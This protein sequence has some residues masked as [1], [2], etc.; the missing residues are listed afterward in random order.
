MTEPL[1]LFRPVAERYPILQR[2]GEN[3]HR[4]PR[5]KGHTGLDFDTPLRT[6]VFAAMAG[7]VIIIGKDDSYGNYLMIAQGDLLQVYAHLWR[8]PFAIVRLNE[9]VNQGQLI[10]LSGDSGWSWPRANIPHLHFE[11]RRGNRPFDPEPFLQGAPPEEM[12]VLQN[13]EEAAHFH[14]RIL[15]NAFPYLNLRSEPSIEAAILGKLAP[16]EVVPVSQVEGETV[17]CRIPGRGWFAM[18]Y[19]GERYAASLPPGEEDDDHIE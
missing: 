4:Y 11:M 3:P 12:P 9:R 18:A 14:A 17:W 5:S 19:Q 7:K 1:K 13:G 6:P 8:G 10:A 15:E 2:F 16:G